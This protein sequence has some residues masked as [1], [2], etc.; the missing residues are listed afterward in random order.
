MTAEDHEERRDRRAQDDA[1]RELAELA[2]RAG[3]TLS[4]WEETRDSVLGSL[5]DTRQSADRLAESIEKLA[6]KEDLDTVKTRARRNT[7]AI[8]L[9]LAAVLVLGSIVVSGWI[10]DRNARERSDREVNR[11]VCEI[12]RKI[13]ETVE[14]VLGRF[15]TSTTTSTTVKECS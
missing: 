1:A 5:D 13:D 12:G 11:V 15:S 9:L 7:A 3:A 4:A 8:A 14:H 10:S 2:A 6:S